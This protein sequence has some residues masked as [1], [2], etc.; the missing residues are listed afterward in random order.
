M[1]TNHLQLP[2][3]RQKLHYTFCNRDLEEIGKTNF[4]LLSKLN[5]IATRPPK[6]GAAG[7]V[8]S[9]RTSPLKL[10]SRAEMEREKRSQQIDRD[11]LILLKKIQ[12][13]KPDVKKFINTAGRGAGVSVTQ[14]WGLGGELSPHKRPKW[15]DPTSSEVPTRANIRRETGGSIMRGGGAVSTGG[16]MFKD[17][18]FVELEAC[19]EKHLEK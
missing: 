12:S 4:A 2:A 5:S 15:V 1:S 8:A 3:R 6:F 10:R 16:K 13:T 7:T 17:S 19:P 18:R 11:N 9:S 14:E